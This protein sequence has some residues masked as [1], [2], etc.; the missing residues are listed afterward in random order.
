[1]WSFAWCPAKLFA[2]CSEKINVILVLCGSA[3]GGVVMQAVQH[4]VTF[5][6]IASSFTGVVCLSILIGFKK[7]MKR[8][9]SIDYAVLSKFL[10]V[11]FLYFIVNF[12]IFYTEF[13][14]S[15]S[16]SALKNL[17]L[18]IYDLL[19]TGCIYLCIRLNSIMGKIIT[20]IF[21]ITGAIYM[22]LWLLVYVNVFPDGGMMDMA[23]RVLPG[24]IFYS[25][26]IGILLTCILEQL[27]YNSDVW[28][29][30]YLITVD[31]AMA[32]HM[33]LLYLA[34]FYNVFSSVFIP[35]QGGYPYLFE[36]LLLI[37][38]LINVYTIIYLAVY[39][40]RVMRENL[41]FDAVRSDEVKKDLMSAAGEDS[42]P[43]A[44]EE[45]EEMEY[46]TEISAREKDVIAHVVRGMSNPEIAEE[47]CISVYTVKRH[48]NSIFK[49]YRVK[50]RFELLQKLNNEKA[51]RSDKRL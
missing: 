37:F 29:K 42:A 19:F 11:F 18:F 33:C 14:L 46:S 25:V 23:M 15:A 51:N 7:I 20:R 48:M 35:N 41:S 8:T 44:K 1:M 26:T 6:F 34:D 24:V 21:L 38:P 31:I 40:K 32:V 2:L 30:K 36:P 4:I 5:S 45:A 47:L 43:E 39:I 27:R 3:E 13:F 10:T 49:K 50:S 17:E 9:F 22:L 28:E 16:D 12:L